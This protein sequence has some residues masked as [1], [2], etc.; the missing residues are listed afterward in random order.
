MG[1]WM[2]I[3]IRLFT[4]MRI[5]IQILALKKRLKPL[6]KCLNRRIFHTFWLDTCK[7]M[8][9]RIRF[10]IQLINFYADPDFMTR[11]RIQVT[12]VMRILADLD[13][14]PQ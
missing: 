9:I 2:R 13:P 8:R 3:W 1:I 12:K 10:R 6:K 4:L 11:M 7:L 14:D 5:L